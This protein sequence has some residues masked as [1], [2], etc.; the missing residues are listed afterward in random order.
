MTQCQVINHLLGGIS[1]FVINDNEISIK[2]SG[3]TNN[4]SCGI[5]IAGVFGEVEIE[6][7]RILHNKLHGLALSGGSRFKVWNNEIEGNRS[8][9]LI[10]S[11]QVNLLKNKIKKN[12]K[13]GLVVKTEDKILADVKVMFNIINKNRLNGILIEGNEFIIYIYSTQIIFL[14]LFI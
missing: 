5:D 6:N 1:C 11:A 4:G 13:H 7:S 2:N 14:D 3:I 12:I 10:I 9:V 8:G